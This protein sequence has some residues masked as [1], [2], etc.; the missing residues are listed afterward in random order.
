MRI[1]AL[2]FEAKA[3]DPAANLARIEAAAG[4]AAEAGAKLLV[5]PELCLSGY[6]AGEA[7]EAQA[8]PLDG[9]LVGRLQAI[10]RNN[11]L[12]IITGFSERLGDAIAN[13]ALFLDGTRVVAYRKAFLY[14]DYEKDLFKPGRPETVIVEHAGLKIGMLICYDVEFPENVRRLALAGVDLVA[15][16]TALPATE[17]APF[18]AHSIV[19]VR[20]F[21]NQVHVA[22]VDLCGKDERFSYAGL[23]TVAAPDGRVLA[24]AGSGEELIFADIDPAGFEAAREENPYLADLAAVTGRG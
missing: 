15:V 12:A 2:Q 9:P 18:I 11:G 23:S 1:A 10:A 5:A 20:A 21:E 16:P 7:H 8:E 4:R 13:S 17:H 6:G 22:Y 3:G 24:Q 19:P 14:G